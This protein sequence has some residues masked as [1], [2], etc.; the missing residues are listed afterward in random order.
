[1]NETE[2]LKSLGRDAS[3]P[4]IDVAANVLREIRVRQNVRSE[5]NLAWPALLAT[6]AGGG[7]ATAA[8]WIVASVQDP[9]MG[10]FD[11]V[12]MVLQ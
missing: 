3:A 8:F 7:M 2:W 11:A 5:P 12:K 6:L 9:F 10:L 1:M 4:Q